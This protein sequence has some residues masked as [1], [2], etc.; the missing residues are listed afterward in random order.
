MSERRSREGQ[1]GPSLASSREARFAR[2]NR[3]DCSQAIILSA[4]VHYEILNNPPSIPPSHF[5]GIYR[6]GKAQNENVEP[7]VDRS[8]LEITEKKRNSDHIEESIII[9]QEVLIPCGTKFLRALILAIFPAIR[10]NKFPQIK[11]TANIF[12]AKIYFRV[13]IL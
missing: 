1:R 5:A 9:L 6:L 10:K 7:P 3:R 2:L 11:I 8:D 13:N 4:T 12:P